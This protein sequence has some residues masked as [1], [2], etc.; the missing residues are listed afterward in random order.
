MKSHNNNIVS[1]NNNSPSVKSDLSVKSEAV[2][3][4]LVNSNG[5]KSSSQDVSPGFSPKPKS[6]LK[7]HNQI[8]M[9]FFGKLI[10]KMESV[11]QTLEDV[12]P[13][14]PKKCCPCCSIQ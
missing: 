1:I 2:S 8:S 3:E 5:S 12:S 4:I 9:S 14:P 6:K 11:S 7:Q 13:S 10:E